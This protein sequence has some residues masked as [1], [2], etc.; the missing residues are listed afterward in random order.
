[1][2]QTASDKYI[3]RR[4]GRSCWPPRAAIVVANLYYA[5]PLLDEIAHGLHVSAGS[6]GLLVTLSQV[7]YALG[8]LFVVPLG[9][10]LERRRLIVVVLAAAVLTLIGAGLSP[11]LPVLGA[12]L[13][14][15]GLTSVVA[16]I[17]VPFAATLAGDDERGKV[18]G[19][20]MTGLLLGILLARTASGLVGQWLGWRAVFLVAAIP[21]VALIVV[22]RAE[23]PVV[24]PSAPMP[25]RQ[26]LRSVLALLQ[27]HPT[28]RIRC[29]L[30]ALG[31]AAFSLFWTTM[32]F[33]LAGA[34]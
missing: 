22:L 26:A 23:L 17:L 9:D 25:Y 5:Q 4:L 33:L 6:A 18:V 11:D 30:G 29:A 32:A 13:L 31:M 15:G 10:L 7:G 24:A 14:L 12:F 21:M 2:Q 19:T 8:L 20:V 28:L 1:M 3:P 16:Q 34:P 27:E